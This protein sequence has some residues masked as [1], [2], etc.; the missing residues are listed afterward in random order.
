MLTDYK[1]GHSQTYTK[2]P[3]Y[4]DSELIGGKK[5]QL[6]FTDKVVMMIIRDEATQLASLRTGK[7]DL[8]MVMNTKHVA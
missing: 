7:I 3:K 5:Y 4:W 8:M 1:E 2:N 6:P